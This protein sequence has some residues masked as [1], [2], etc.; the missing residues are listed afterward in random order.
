[1][2]RLRI[3]L[4]DK[5]KRA[6]FF[7]F[8][9]LLAQLPVPLAYAIARI[10]GRLKMPRHAQSRQAMV[11]NMMKVLN[12]GRRE[13][14]FFSRKVFENQSIEEFEACFLPRLSKRF[15]DKYVQFEGLCNL[16]LT[17]SRGR[18][19][20]LACF[21]YGSFPLSASLLGLAGYKVHAVAAYYGDPD[22]G[23]I[24]SRHIHNKVK[25]M[26]HWMKGEFFFVGD[27][28]GFA[29]RREML[30]N[31]AVVILADAQ[32]GRSRLVPVDFLGKKAHMPDTIF[33]L[34]R[35]TG[36]SV[37][38]YVTLRE[39]NRLQLK[40]ILEKPIEPVVRDDFEEYRSKM[41]HLIDINSRFIKNYP[42]QWFYI[43]TPVNWA[44]LESI[45]AKE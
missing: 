16:D 14:D 8:L 44:A 9:P 36:A 24:L 43:S 41:Q 21:H 30:Q 4:L 1:M 32:L 7:L 11:A 33:R 2:G 18:G 28:I 15:V 34:S 29:L 27:G 38:P 31:T 10:R 17:L 3:F 23:N 13:A 22:S 35:L 5:C 6:D 19:A 39:P 26:K 45:W 12:I 20:I 42:D 37:I 25:W 40:I